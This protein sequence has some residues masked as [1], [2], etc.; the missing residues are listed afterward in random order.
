MVPSKK[1]DIR[2][3]PIKQCLDYYV[4]SI[5][6]RGFFCL[7]IQFLLKIFAEN[8]FVKITSTNFIK[9]HFIINLGCCHKVFRCLN[10]SLV[11]YSGLHTFK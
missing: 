5:Y 1:Q 2:R 6:F 10:T 4:N 11:R 7:D 9:L 8:C 3:L